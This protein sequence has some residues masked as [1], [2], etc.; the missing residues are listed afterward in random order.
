MFDRKKIAAFAASL[1]ICASFSAAPMASHADDQPEDTAVADDN[2]TVSGDFSYWLTRDDTVCI[3][4]CKAIGEK[5]VIPDTIDGK[6]VTELGPM[7]FGNDPLSLPFTSIELPASINYISEENP[8]MYCQRLKEI[9]VADGCNDFCSEDGVLYT[10]KKDR[11]ICYPNCKEG[12]SF[13]V[14][15]GVETL[16]T[17]C[18]YNADFSELSLPKSLKTIGQF[19][20]G[21]ITGLTKL[22]LSSTSVEEIKPY[23]F[24]GCSSLEEIIFPETLESI[25]GGAFSSCKALT[26]VT[27][28]DSLMEIGQYAFV[29]TGLTSAI[30]PD[31]VVSIGYCAF[32]YASGPNGI[33]A[34]DSFIIVG[35][36]GSAA[37]LYAVDS[38]TDYDYKNNFVFMSPSEFEGQKELLSLEK[39]SSGD[40]EYAITSEGAV[41]TLC[42]SSDD[43]VTVPSELDGHTILTIYPACFSACQASEITLPDT[44]TEI[45]EMAFYNC[46]A[47]RSLTIPA[48]VK[49]IGDNAFDSCSSLESIEFLGAETIGTN[50]L[51]KCKALKT[52]KSAAT[53]KEWNDPKPFA[54]C[55]SLEEI[56]INGSGGIY[57]SEDGIL[58]NSDKT[59]LIAYPA[60]RKGSSFTL[61]KNI[62][63]IGQYAFYGAAELTEADLSSAESIMDF[64]F[65]NCEN[66]KKVK[67][68]SALKTIGS[69]AFYNCKALKSLRLDKSVNDIGACAFGYIYQEKV[70]SDDASKTDTIMEDFRLYAPKGSTAYKYADALGMNVVGGTM[71]IFGKNYDVH[72]IG[73]IAAM[74][75]LFIGVIAGRIIGKKVKAKKAEKE[76]AERRERA[77]ERLKK[78]AEEAAGNASSDD[79][80]EDDEDAE[81]EEDEYEEEEDE[82]ADETEAEDEEEEEETDED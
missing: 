5:L 74:L 21:D 2:L 60:A 37:Q 43:A 42:K 36:Q 20:M 72:L 51:K 27:F 65:E 30:I 70:N 11:L 24:S 75:L 39:I 58:Y 45:R 3:E 56:T 10:K 44:I 46:S 79:D 7:A 28:P 23:A 69:K 53:I 82:E 64:A 40:F 80:S 71:E 17:A 62:K 59:T 6:K 8:F 63:E 50:I 78:R 57:S 34:D 81:Y 32:G 1:L 77:A 29:D 52:F 35:S 25:N 26:E 14:P 47:L 73:F 4:D 18:F 49:K 22:D 41:L 16:G 61:P 55:K 9:K 31:S 19:S 76:L 13:T 33:V 15:E 38:D 12:D 48:S 54:D 68:S 66:L 67:T